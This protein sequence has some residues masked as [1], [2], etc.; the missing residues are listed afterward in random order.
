MWTR[1]GGLVLPAYSMDWVRVLSPVSFAVDRCAWRL[2]ALTLLRGPARL[3]DRIIDRF[4]GNRG[5]R[6]S[7]LGRS[8]SSSGAPVVVAVDRATFAADFMR[9]TRRFPLRPDYD[10]AQIDHVVGE[11]TRLRKNGPAG[12]VAVRTH[13]GETIGAAIFHL[14]AGSTAR[15]LQVVAE[16]RWTGAVLDALFFHLRDIGAIGVLG[17]S[18]PMLTEAMLPRR[19]AF[20]PFVATVAHS[21]D[22]ELLAVIRTG[23]AFFNGLVGEKWM[24]LVEEPLD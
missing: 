10:A 12:L 22:P 21:R 5:S 7:S 8:P 19:I 4:A 24:R 18:Q 11:A 6:W 3:A 9:L 13:T 23:G 1:L 16:E 17:R 20:L 15:I 14:R 2:P